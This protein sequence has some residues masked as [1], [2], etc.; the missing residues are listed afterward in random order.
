MENKDTNQMSLFK[1]IS[2]LNE[3]AKQTFEDKIAITRM[4]FI[5]KDFLTYEEIFKGYN[6]IRVITY[7]YSLSFIEKIM[8]YFDRGEVII[9]FDKMI[10]NKTAELF[11]LQEYSTNYICNSS[12]LQEQINNDKFRFYVLND[13]VSHQKVYLLKADDG[14]VR[15]ITGS[16]NFSERAWNG[17][18][19][20]CVTICDDLECYEEYASQYEILQRLSTAEIS[21][22]ATHIKEDGENANELPIFKKI[23]KE[24]AIVLHEVQNEEYQEYIFHTDNLADEWENRLRYVKLKPSK[25]GKIKLDIK[26]MKTILG[27]IRKDNV[28]KRERQ[29]IN[30]QFVIDYD[31]HA[32]TYN[33]VPFN[34]N[35]N[36]DLVKDDL[37]NLIEYMD[38]F[39]LFTK[40]TKRLKTLY[41]KVLNYMFLSPFIARLRYEGDR[42]GYEDRFFP[43]YMLIYGDSDAGKTGFINLTRQLMF[44]EKLN[45]LTQD[46][47]SSKPMT[48]LKVDVKG[49]PILIDELT[50]T[51]WK[52]AKDIVKMDVNLIRKKLINHPTF[53]MLSNDINN[54]APELSKRIVVINLDNRL[55]RTSAAY[56]G[57]KINTIR[58]NI[59]N[60]LYC[61]YLRRM[62]FAVDSLILTIQEHDEEGKDEWI[63]DIFEVSSNIL[64]NIMKDFDIPVPMEFHAFTWFDYMGDA[65]I[66]EKST[67]IIKD[68][69]THNSSIFHID[70]F[71]N[72]LEIDF[73][74]YDSN[75]SK[76]KLHVLHDELPAHVEC[77]IV[78]TKAVLKLD[79]I[80]KYSGINFKKK[81]FW[82]RK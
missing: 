48:S 37:K 19:I 11:A 33:Q 4:Q 47:F 42:Y 76:K 22:D 79:A 13:L 54:V 9:G 40:D 74:C 62:F 63:P 15:T 65:V 26:K 39:N 21:K 6:E 10:N 61:E 7:S 68:E 20:E 41:W 23:E 45:S 44:N 58:K 14:R 5:S 69:Y 32:V 78:G 35:P 12:Y 38:G 28:K 16:A 50:P 25:D 75:E 46:Y 3:E 36:K 2:G 18:Q 71:K 80:K 51:Y 56:N 67:N 59:H 1:A 57:K 64:L 55:D 82:R 70:T 73:S 52:Y 31:N 60:A 43:M 66:G 77:K 49:C 30:P 29:L 24:N 72:E 8:H 53:V 17:E 81:P 27:S 34:L